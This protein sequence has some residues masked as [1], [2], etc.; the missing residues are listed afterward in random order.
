MTPTVKL[1]A[2]LNYT[3]KKIN[4]IIYDNV[5]IDAGQSLKYWTNEMIQDKLATTIICIY[6]ILDRIIFF[7][8]KS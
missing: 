6:R 3:E 7:I 5:Y 2:R 1:I 8:D 4:D